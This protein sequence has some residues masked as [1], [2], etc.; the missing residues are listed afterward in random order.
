VIE[1]IDPAAA[2][3]I[4]AEDA[5]DTL[6]TGLALYLERY[7]NVGVT[8]RGTSL[9]PKSL[10]TYRAEYDVPVPTNEFGPATLSVI[11]WS[12]HVER[13]LLLCDASGITLYAE[14]PGI[15]APQFDFTSY[16][17]WS[18]FRHYEPELA[19]AQLHPVTGPVIDAAKDKLREHFR[20]RAVEEQTGILE[21]WKSEDVYPYAEDAGD[22]L[23]QVERNLFDVVAATAARAVN[24]SSDKIGK[25]FSLRLLREAIEQSPSALRRVLHEVLELPESSLREL[26]DLLDRTSL[27][28]LIALGKV[29]SD[30]LDFLAGL[31]ELIFEPKSRKAVLERTQLHRILVDEAWIFGDEYSLAVDDEGLGAVLEQHIKLL[32]RERTAADL[33][34]ALLEDGSRAIVDLLFA[35]TIPLATQ[36][37]EH[38]VVE[39]KRPSLTLGHE[40]VTQIERYAQAVARDPRFD[41][42]NVRWNFW[43]VGTSMDDFVAGRATQAHL[44]SG[45]VSQPLDG[46]VTVRVKTWSQILDDCEQRLKYVRERLA[47]RST[48]DAGVEYL[49][50]HHQKFLPELLRS[51]S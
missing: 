43:L 22:D 45:V 19:A 32:G 14:H 24:S 48:R 2:G 36:Q 9:D 16:V 4:L 17:S 51:A 31:G 34:P 26:D 8:F 29:V 44:P 33:D 28:S 30:R 10:Q 27:T 41:K 39:L 21:Q 13:E 5:S 42:V 40:E 3:A 46:R 25:R 35:Q 18:G 47:Y 15:Q 50:L 6:T 1:D 11:E 49:R 37:H 38:L 7:P 20:V 12:R 23:E